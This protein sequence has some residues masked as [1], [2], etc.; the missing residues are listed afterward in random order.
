MKK[1]SCNIIFPILGVAAVAAAAGFTYYIVSK[2]KS[3]KVEQLTDE[4]EFSKFEE[5]LVESGFT[6]DSINEFKKIYYTDFINKED[7][8]ESFNAFIRETIENQK[9]ENIQAGK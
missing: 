1:K 2:S 8:E 9:K 6:P 5:K 7:T 4:N 3:K